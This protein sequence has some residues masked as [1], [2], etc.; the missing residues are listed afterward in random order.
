MFGK[1]AGEDVTYY[2]EHGRLVTCP[3]CD[4]KSLLDYNRKLARFNDNAK[5]G[6]FWFR[7]LGIA[8]IGPAATEWAA[9]E[10]DMI[11]DGAVHAHYG[12]GAAECAVAISGQQRR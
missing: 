8:L 9:K 2:C 5:R 11:R 12:A 7:E 6:A 3:T 10:A 4:D 1:E